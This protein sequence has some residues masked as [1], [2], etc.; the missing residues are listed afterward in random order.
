MR[1]IC[2]ENSVWYDGPHKGEPCAHK[3]SIYHVTGTMEGSE[4]RARFGH[5]FADGTWYSFLEI[6]GCHHGIRFLEIPDDDMLSETK[7][8]ETILHNQ[9]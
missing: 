1:V 2:I 6:E 8:E 9:N 5:P 3:G 4:M 7:L